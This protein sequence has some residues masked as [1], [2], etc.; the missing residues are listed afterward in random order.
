MLRQR[1]HRPEK[2]KPWTLAVYM[3]ADGINGSSALDASA[4][5]AQDDIKT[6]L[7]AAGANGTVNVAMQMD[8]KETPGTRRL[9]VHRHRDWIHLGRDEDAGDPRVLERFFRW[10]HSE[11]PA[12]RYVVHFWGHSS[13]PVGLFFERSPRDARPHG[14][15]LPELGYAFEHSM[16]ILGQLVDIVL[17]KDCWMSTLEAACELRDGAKFMVSSQSLVPID[18]WPYQEMF[19]CLSSDETPI[20]A[21]GLVEVL[22]DYYDAAMHRPKLNEVAFGAVD[23]DAARAVDEPL[24]ALAGRLDALHGSELAASRTGVRRSSRG[25]PALVDIVTMC[26]NLSNLAD[27]ELGRHAADLSH[28]VKASVI[29]HRP[30]PSVFQGLSLLYIPAGAT[31]AE[32]AQDSFIVPPFYQ[33]GLNAAG[34]YRTLELSRNTGWERIAL[35]NFKPPPKG[36]R[37][38][39]IE[40][41]DK[42][43]DFGID[44]TDDG[45]GTLT[46]KITKKPKKKAKASPKSSRATKKPKK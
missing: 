18:G 2:L 25:D 13:G 3:I 22:G 12:E 42:G 24:R 33:P 7:A 23:V 31:L 43:G 41:A 36:K 38:M 15:T 39:P 34:D 28:A 32:Q 30:G 46:V 37:A 9:I 5:Q 11:C 21:A 6:A 27:A 10:V 26:D 19:D 8:F 45:S 20:V 17:F 35:E 1:P 40:G 44:W 14:L 4:E 16:P 29:A